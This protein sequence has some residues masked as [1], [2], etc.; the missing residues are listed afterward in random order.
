MAEQAAA[1]ASAA[2]SGVDE[3]SCT[4]DCITDCDAGID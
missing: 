4:I 1:K 2:K 3:T